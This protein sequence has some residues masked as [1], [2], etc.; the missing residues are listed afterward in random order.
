LSYAG[1]LCAL[2]AIVALATV[3]PARKALRLDLA[4]VLHY[5]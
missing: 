3:M 2:G 4:K 5:E 1:A